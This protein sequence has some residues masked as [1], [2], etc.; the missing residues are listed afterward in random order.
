MKRSYELEVNGQ[1]H[2]LR[3]LPN[4]GTIPG[5]TGG[6]CGP[7]S[8]LDLRDRSSGAAPETGKQR[9]D[10]IL[11]LRALVAEEGRNYG[12]G[13]VEFGNFSDD[14]SFGEYDVEEAS[15]QVLLTNPRKD[16]A[17]RTTWVAVALGGWWDAR[18][19]DIAASTAGLQN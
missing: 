3:L 14:V 2:C 15:L 9:L 4:P 1:T 8:I 16:I 10:N 11:Q 13:G 6:D 5:G 19:L 18:H 7:M 17:K 12:G